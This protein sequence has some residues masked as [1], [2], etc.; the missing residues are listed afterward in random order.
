MLLTCS[1]AR[2]TQ[3]S[4][5]PGSTRY[6]ARCGIHKRNPKKATTFLEAKQENICLDHYW[7]HV[8]LCEANGKANG[9]KS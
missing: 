7:G 8:V 6:G 3:R 4:Q 1:C 2:S 5:L 9:K